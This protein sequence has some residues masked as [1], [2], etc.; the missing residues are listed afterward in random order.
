MTSDKTP[1]VEAGQKCL[2]S[3]DN[4]NK[5]FHSDDAVFERILARHGKKDSDFSVL[6]ME[7]LRSSRAFEQFIDAT[8]KFIS[9]RM[10][11]DS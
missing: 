2:E 7:R 10:E 3:I 6:A 9:L 1:Y 11:N 5:C 4:F 8:K